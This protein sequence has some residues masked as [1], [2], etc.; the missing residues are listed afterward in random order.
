MVKLRWLSSALADL[1]DIYDFIA[2]DSKQFAKHQI[3]Q[4]RL[5]TK[6][7]KSYPKIGKVVVEYNEESIRE[8]IVGHY[9]IIYK[10]IDAQLIHIILIHHGARKFPRI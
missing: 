7:L 3:T 4:I 6:V 10:I 9:R 5:K 8:I 1:Q 2:V